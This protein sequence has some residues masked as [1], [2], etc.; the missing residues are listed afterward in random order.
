MPDTVPDLVYRTGV[1][2]YL[3]KFQTISAIAQNV[4]LKNVYIVMP[5]MCFL[6]RRVR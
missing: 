1:W 5:K 2:E 4:V 3:S 6:L